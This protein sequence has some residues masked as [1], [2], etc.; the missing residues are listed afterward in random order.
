MKEKESIRFSGS[1]IDFKRGF[2]VEFWQTSDQI[3]HTIFGNIIN[4]K[5]NSITC[6]ETEV[7]AR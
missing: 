2:S 5:C 3:I 7:E 1:F 4:Y 6:N